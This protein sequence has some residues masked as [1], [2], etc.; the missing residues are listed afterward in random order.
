MYNRSCIRMR[1]TRI[2]SRRGPRRLQDLIYI[3]FFILLFSL[4]IGPYQSQPFIY[5]SFGWSFTIGKSKILYLILIDSFFGKEYNNVK[6]DQFRNQNNLPSLQY[7]H[8]WM[9][10]HRMSYH[11][12]LPISLHCVLSSPILKYW[13]FLD[14]V[15]FWWSLC[16]GNWASPFRCQNVSALLKASSCSNTYLDIMY[17]S[18]GTRRPSDKEVKIFVVKG[19]RL[20]FSLATSGM[21]MTVYI[22]TAQLLSLFNKLIKVYILNSYCFQL[23]RFILTKSPIFNFLSFHF[24]E[25]LT[26]F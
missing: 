25:I 2:I 26:Y 15:S 10:G 11:T 9:P 21:M 1:M 14:K 17:K 7:L 4:Y 12:V 3:V 5:N 22:H 16:C 20:I 8:P 6:M 19:S 13:V 18:S 24:S 23:I